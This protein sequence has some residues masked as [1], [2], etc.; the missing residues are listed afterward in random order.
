MREC[1]T[2]SERTAG[3]GGST[4][5]LEISVCL[6]VPTTGG[7]ASFADC[8]AGI[9]ALDIPA[10]VRFSV[11]VVENGREVPELT[12]QD[13]PFPLR[14]VAEPQRGIPFARNAA[15]DHAG[16]ADY[17]AFID[18]D[19][20][21]DRSW[22]AEMVKALRETG[23]EAVSGPQVPVFPEGSPDHLR[24]AAIYR[25]RRFEHGALVSWAASNNVLFSL[26]FAR[27]NGLRFDEKMMTGGT[28]KVFFLHFTRSG[29]RI[30]W[31]PDAVVREPVTEAR[32]NK[33]WAI[34]RAWRFGSTGYS[35]ERSSHGPAKGALICLFKGAGYCALAGVT[36]LRSAIPGG[37]PVIDASCALVHGIGFF[38]GLFP[39]FRIR[40]YA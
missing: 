9:A 31:A 2:P 20:A 25:E 24:Q 38:A 22:L 32:L 13:F 29:G 15:L 33:R 26:D 18:D 10:G 39:R 1:P 7:R 6:A 30:A 23:C 8:L 14:S 40:R 4:D 36:A 21:P 16:D 27:R 35:I 3:P 19:A 5:L 17:L 28:D 34:M 37:P 11:L 12:V